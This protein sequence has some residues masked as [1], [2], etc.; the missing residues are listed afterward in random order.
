AQVNR[1]PALQA[2][3][4]LYNPT[5]FFVGRSDDLTA[6]QYLE[7]VDAVYGAGADLEAIAGEAKLDAFIEAAN[8][9][10]PPRILG[11]VISVEDDVEEPTKRVRVMGQ[12]FVPDAS[13]FPER[14]Y[15][16][17]GTPEEPRMLPKGLDVHAA[18]GPERA[19][20]LREE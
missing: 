7:V 19:Y 5:V 13:I 10:P 2:W 16:N 12:R 11:I 17:V 1:A 6:L 18:M 14:L 8:Q 9:L 15:R 4:D 3:L 20:T